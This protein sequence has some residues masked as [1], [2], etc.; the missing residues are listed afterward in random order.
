MSKRIYDP[1]SDDHY[2]G[3]SIH[4]LSLLIAI[5][6]VVF[7]DIE[8]ILREKSWV[9]FVVA[10]LQL[11]AIVLLFVGN[12]KFKPALYYVFFVLCIVNFCLAVGEIVYYLTSED[13]SA[14]ETARVGNNNHF[15]KI[16]ALIVL[17]FF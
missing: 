16:I 10:T 7:F 15:G 13:N 3:V 2:C 11:T 4:L 14:N 1:E 9:A 12:R 8:H 17:L 6:L 5:V